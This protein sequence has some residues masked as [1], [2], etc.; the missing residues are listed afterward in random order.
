MSFIK[1]G[2]RLM[3]K[4]K[5]KTYATEYHFLPELEKVKLK[6]HIGRVHSQLKRIMED[7]TEMHRQANMPFKK[8]RH[9]HGGYYTMIEIVGDLD[10]HL[11]E[12]KDITESM[13]GRWNTVFCNAEDDIELI[14]LNDAKNAVKELNNNLFKEQ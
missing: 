5:G 4:R 3:E 9:E 14:D 6:K 11:K 12:G 1:T 10:R 13:L 2:S 7:D 8:H